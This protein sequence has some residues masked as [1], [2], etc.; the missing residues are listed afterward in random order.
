MAK[1]ALPP[2]HGKLLRAAL[3]RT[4]LLPVLLL[5]F[6]IVAPSWY[7]YR[8]HASLRDEIIS[9]QHITESEKARRIDY[10]DN[11]DLQAVCFHHGPRIQRLY[12]AFE[13]S[14][15]RG[16]FERLWWGLLG[17][18]ILVA[19]LLITMLSI[20]S[21]NLDAR[22][23]L[24]DL[25]SN[26][27]L[28][29]KFAM[30]TAVIKLV[31]LIPLMAYGSFE[32]TVLLTNYFLPKLLIL[33]IIGGLFAL[34]ASFKV[35]LKRVPLE[36]SEPMSREITPEEA[37]ELWETI[38]QA[39]A[40]LETTPPDRVVVGLKI[41]FYVTELMVKTDTGSTTGRT[42]FLP[43]L[44]L[45][46]LSREEVLAII[47]HELGHF[48]RSDTRMTREFYPLRLKVN[49][50]IMALARSGWVG[51]PSWGLLAFFSLTF[52]KTIQ[53]ISRKRELLADQVG[54]NLTSP[55]IF[56]RALVKFSV[57]NET[58]QRMLKDP[59]GNQIQNPMEIRWHAFIDEKILADDPFWSELAEKKLPHP[60]DS[61]PSLQDRLQALG[62]VV[63]VNEAR[64]ISLQAGESA[65]DVWF[66]GHEGLFSDLNQKV[67]KAVDESRVRARLAQAN[68]QTT[69]GK[70][71]LEQHFPEIRWRQKG[72]AHV[73]GLVIFGIIALFCFFIMFLVPDVLP[74]VFL[75]LVVAL[76]I[77]IAWVAWNSRTEEL[78]L[79]ADGITS[80]HWKRMLR[81]TEFETVELRR[82]NSTLHVKLNFKTRQA[83]PV[84]WSLFPT[85]TAVL[86]PLRA[87]WD[88]KPNVMAQTIFRYFMRDPAVVS[89]T[90]IKKTS[91]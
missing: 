34:W 61:H 65:Y 58:L 28:S 88:E 87:G 64:A 3:W 91:T 74:K 25:I 12:E 55:E 7:S 81:F 15:V 51:W 57:L 54:A 49:E 24:N 4:L 35:L 76:F 67:D 80:A 19:L 63:H 90:E 70:E 40:A 84:K 30:T 71:L 73:V 27:R 9:S 59:A 29:W 32:F 69:E 2:D 46:Q 82:I 77:C 1:Q 37:P 41:S 83:S 44:L 60:L 50:T 36:F 13:K 85:C 21:M 72:S 14:G 47:G 66:V 68:Y 17:S 39:A 23:S 10:F 26:Y 45:K 22:K 33:I 62:G 11:L 6:F 75:G 78:L 89:D 16:T 48:K 79:T 20:M 53:G 31:L 43:Y 42:L 56:A 8:V 38:R 5:I 52:E 18:G 86:L